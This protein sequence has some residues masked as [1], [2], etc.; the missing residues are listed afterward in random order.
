MFPSF[1]LLRGNWRA[2]LTR[3]SILRTFCETREIP[4]LIRVENFLGLEVIRSKMD[5]GGL[6]SFGFG[7]VAIFA[8][9]GCSA[10]SCSTVIR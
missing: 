5:K 1:G 4:N 7:L 10:L 6:R 9:F 8:Y 3:E 2:F